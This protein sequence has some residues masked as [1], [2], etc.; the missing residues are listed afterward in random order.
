[1]TESQVTG[2]LS[3]VKSPNRSAQSL[4]SAVAD[5][6]DFVIIGVYNRLF[7]SSPLPPLQSESKCEVFVMVNSSTF[8]YEL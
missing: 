7:P 3:S 4:L 1:M 8:T 6:N 5:L 2:K